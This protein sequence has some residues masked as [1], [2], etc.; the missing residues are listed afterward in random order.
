MNIESY[1]SN[2][3][4]NLYDIMV[5]DEVMLILRAL[6]LLAFYTHTYDT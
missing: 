1:V 3:I 5:F 6:L 2:K 4:Q